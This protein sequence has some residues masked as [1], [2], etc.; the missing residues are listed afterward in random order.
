MKTTGEVSDALKQA[1][2]R[3]YAMKESMEGEENMRHMER[4]VC[5]DV[6]DRLWKE[7]L[8]IMDDVRES[9]YFMVYGQRD[10]LQEYK[11]NAYEAFADFMGRV[12]HEISTEIFR[13]TSV[14]P[15]EMSGMTASDTSF[16]HEILD[17]YSQKDMAEIATNKPGG[18]PKK[19]PFVHKDKQVG[20]N[21]PC[22]CGSGKKFKKCC[23]R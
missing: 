3:M 10:P 22:P 23:G 17:S 2:R 4:F 19:T 11:K 5:L 16:Q 18:G 14:M 7:Q 12:D 6:I 21:D 13:L 15:H 20:R 8:R 1:I 9:A